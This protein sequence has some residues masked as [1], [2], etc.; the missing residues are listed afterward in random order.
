MPDIKVKFYLEQRKDKTTGQIIKK[1]VPIL[2]SCSFGSRYKSTTGLRVNADQWNRKRQTVRLHPRADN[3]NFQLRK[4]KKR[5]HELFDLAV[6]NDVPLTVAYFKNGLRIKSKI[7]F[8][9]HL[10][11]FIEQGKKRWQLATMKK[12][13]TLKAHL[14][15]FR[16]KRKIKIEY[17]EMNDAWFEKYM[18]YYFEERQFINSHVRKMIRFLQQFM[19]WSTEQGYNRNEAFRKWKLETG[20]K[21]ERTD[22]NIVSLTIP[23]FLQVYEY[24][25]KSTAQERAKD[26]LILACST[27][28]RYSDIAGLRK[29]DVD[30]KNGLIR[31]TTVKT[32]DLALIP[33]NDFSREV[34]LKYQHT[35]NH[36]KGLDRASPVST[37]QKLNITLKTL[38]RDA[39]IN[40]PVS[41]VHFKRNQRIDRVVPK[42]NLISSHIGRK[43]FVTFSI[44]FQIPAEVVMSMTTHRNHETMEK[45]YNAKDEAP[46][47]AAM[48]K[49]NI[50]TLREYVKQTSN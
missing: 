14:Q 18:D 6:K 49:F 25:P 30:Y 5:L 42:C 28:L 8:L 12:F 48:Q 35:P 9:D 15:D 17:K 10:D 44:W 1:N 20:G 34:L 11:E 21:R 19:I 29:T 23:E 37:N 46:R 50:S 4:I 43:T 24:K 27:G 45:Y 36:E 41:I 7:G 40:T 3:Y 13:L 47:R 22:D 32:G 2:F 16:D 38:A 39:K 33:F 31:V 26:Y